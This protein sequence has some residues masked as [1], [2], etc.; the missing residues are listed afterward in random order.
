MSS[1]SCP[2][3]YIGS[4]AK[5]LPQLLPIIEPASSLPLFDAFSGGFS[6]GANAKAKIVYYNEINPYMEQAV[7]WIYETPID[8]AI[9]DIKAVVNRFGLTK[10][11]RQGF[12]AV[13]NEWNASK[14]DPA[15][16]LAL[17]FYSFNYQQRFNQ[18]GDFNTPFG[19]KRSSFNDHT[20]KKLRA[21]AELIKAKNVI[22]SS[23]SFLDFEPSDFKEKT[24][25]FCDPPYLITTG[26]YND[27]RRGVSSW[28][29]EDEAALLAKIDQLAGFGHLF[30]LTNII[31][32]GN[33]VNVDLEN[34]SK[35]YRVIDLASDYSASNY[36]KKKVSQQE[37]AITNIKGQ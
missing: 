1:Y 31:A 26:S 15:E 33:I 24:V 35:K 25:F 20:E 4:K 6:L 2:F 3:N 30:V 14:N 13:R 19:I 37:I 9:S 21:F 10:T 17:V 28:T 5:L 23:R 12:L 34:W 18:S 27:G 8:A 32:S 36:H 22:F 16:Y 29:K 11:N 7:K